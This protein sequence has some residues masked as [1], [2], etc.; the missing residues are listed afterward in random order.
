VKQRIEA[1]GGIVVGNSPAEYQKQVKDEFEIYKTAV[2]TQG[3][4]PD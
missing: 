2:K 1:T 4:K 3:L